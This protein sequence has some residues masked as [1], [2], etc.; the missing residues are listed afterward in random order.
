MLTSVILI[1]VGLISA[2]VL[3]FVSNR[4]KSR[5]V[6][7]LFWTALLGAAVVSLY[8]GIETIRSDRDLRRLKQEAATIRRFDVTSLVTLA[9]DWKSA[10]PPDFSRYLRTSERGVNIRMEIK[11]KDADMRWIEFTD[12]GPPRIVVGEHN[13]WIL[14]YASHAPAGCWIF[15]VN[16]DDLQTCGTVVMRLYGIDNNTTNDGVLSVNNLTLNF[17]VNG[18][19]VYRCEYNPSLRLQLTPE[20]GS[21]VRLQ[22][23]GPIVM[24]RVKSPIPVR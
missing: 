22:L 15:D 21:P 9:G 6:R 8:F 5:V 4:S 14:D 10:T 3:P 13:T 18:T 19:P 24:Q 1:I 20:L 2:V 12:S 11:T 23:Y 7:G 17:F 16:R